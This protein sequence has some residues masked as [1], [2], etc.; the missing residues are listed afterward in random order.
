MNIFFKFDFWNRKLSMIDVL[1]SPE[2]FEKYEQLFKSFD[3]K[4]KILEN[5]IQE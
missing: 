2:V 1:L 5:N 4:Y 3:I